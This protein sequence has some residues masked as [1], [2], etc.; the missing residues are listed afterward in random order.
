MFTTI[1]KHAVVA[2]ANMAEANVRAGGLGWA[3]GAGKE[4]TS[5]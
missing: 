3:A 5:K 4:T 1:V 2:E